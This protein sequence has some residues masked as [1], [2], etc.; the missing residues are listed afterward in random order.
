MS[1][2]CAIVMYT[3]ALLLLFVVAQRKSA[4][5][6]V[7][8]PLGLIL[9]AATAGVIVFC[10]VRG[11]PVSVDLTLTLA[12]LVVCAASDL[13]TGLIF[14][15]VTAT[16]ACGIVFSAL[17]EQHVAVAVLGAFTGIVPLLG[18][19]ATTRGRGIGLGDVK[20][21]GIIGAGIGSVDALG[22]IGTAFVAGAVCYAPL[23]VTRRMGRGDRVPF[24][25]FMAVGTLVLVAVRVVHGHG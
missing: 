8:T 16:A 4:L 5:V 11:S 22:A 25:P 17:V 20:L 7:K 1:V 3:I 10:T 23:L 21:G 15:A 13:V 12:C 18:L 6:G 9:A 24:A 2:G 14:D 19:Y